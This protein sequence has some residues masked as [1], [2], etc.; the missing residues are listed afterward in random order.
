MKNRYRYRCMYVTNNCYYL[1]YNIVPCL[2]I[3]NNE[4][5]SKVAVQTFL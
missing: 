3:T 4:H 5:N 2:R 1:K